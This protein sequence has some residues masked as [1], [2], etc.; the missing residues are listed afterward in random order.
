[1]ARPWDGGWR[2][3]ALRIAASLAAFA[4]VAAALDRDT[5]A[6][7]YP[8]RVAPAEE[9]AILGAIHDYQVACQDFYAT[10]GDPAL[11]DAVPAT[12]AAKH[13][14][15]RDIGFLRD[16]DL[17]LVEDLAANT[18]LEAQ[19]VGPE[20][21]EVLVFEEWNWT[22]QRKGDRKLV[23]EVRGL[24]QGFRY[25]VAREG[26]RWVVASWDVEDVPAPTGIVEN[27]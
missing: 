19:M 11:L 2:G 26:G 6:P 3:P 7:A 14:I 21:A 16:A 25:Q 1:M 13:Q 17:V 9:P 22:L 5:L 27:W 18:L 24:G 23:S 8:A 4:C 12:K 20:A 10:G 15:F